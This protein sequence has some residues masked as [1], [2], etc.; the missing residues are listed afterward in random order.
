MKIIIPMSGF[1]KRFL[2]AHYKIPKP[3]L[4]VDGKPIIEHIVSMLPGDHEF[5]FI[6][7]QEHL[8]NTNMESILTRV[9]PKSKIIAIPQ[10]SYGPVYSVKN[11]FNEIEDDEDIFITY[12]DYAMEWDFD[13]FVQKVKMG[14]FAGAV[15]A[16]TGF[17]PHLLR[18]ELYAGMLVE[19]GV[20]KDLLEKHS[21]TFNPEESHHSPGAYYFSHGGIFKKYVNE[22]L[23]SNLRHDGEAY[24]SMLYY[25]YLRD[26]HKIYVPEVTRFMQWGTPV[27]LEEY[28]A[29]SRHLHKELG[30]EKGK[31]YIPEERE[32]YVKIPY[33]EDSKQFKDSY[34]YWKGYFGNKG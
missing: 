9:A 7:A 14:N 3:L 11:I 6:C 1:G 13:D 24:V 30:K 27:D 32:R 22:L 4:Q 17:H 20:M 8:S 2:D 33:G 31:T 29:W 26:G 21:F 34:E 5:I 18:R 19:N 16:Y 23:D 15:P 28:E 12:C 10:H 25:L